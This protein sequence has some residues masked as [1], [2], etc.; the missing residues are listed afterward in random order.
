MVPSAAV[1]ATAGGCSA[2]WTV[3]KAVMWQNGSMR[4]AQAEGVVTG[5]TWAYTL[6]CVA[7]ARQA[8]RSAE[9][10][11]WLTGTTATKHNRVALTVEGWLRPAG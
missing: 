6:C 8:E 4:H 2:G 7:D 9:G 10:T 5:V 1:A 11:S 3:H